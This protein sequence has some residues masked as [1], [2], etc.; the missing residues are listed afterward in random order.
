MS[1]TKSSPPGGDKSTHRARKIIL[2]VAIG[3]GLIASLVWAAFLG[4]L[5]IRL[6]IQL[7]L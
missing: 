2:L 3:T 1:P 7:H 4:W 5:V 6:A